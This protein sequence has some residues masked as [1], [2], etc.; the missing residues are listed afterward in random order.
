MILVIGRKRE[1]PKTATE[2]EETSGYPRVEYFVLLGYDVKV[3]ELR[4]NVSQTIIFYP[5]RNRCLRNFGT[6]IYGIKNMSQ[7]VGRKMLFSMTTLMTSSSMM[8][9]MFT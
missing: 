5:G 9:K 3:F 8:I 6:S 1:T 7:P 2:R 4:T